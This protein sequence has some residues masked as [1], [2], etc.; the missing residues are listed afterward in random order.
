MAHTAVKA[1]GWQNTKRHPPVLAQQ[2]LLRHH[3]ELA[4]SHGHRGR[5]PT[6]VSTWS[7]PTI[8]PTHNHMAP[9]RLQAVPRI[10]F[11]QDQDHR[12][13]QPLLQ[14]LP[15]PHRV[16]NQ[17]SSRCKA[18]RLLPAPQ[19]QYSYP[20]KL[21]RPW[22]HMLA[23]STNL[24]IRGDNPRTRARPTYLLTHTIYNNYKHTWA[25][26][27]AFFTRWYYHDTNTHTSSH[28]LTKDRRFPLNPRT[29]QDCCIKKH[30]SAYTFHLIF[31]SSR[32]FKKSF[33]QFIKEALEHLE[34]RQAARVALSGY[35]FHNLKGIRIWTG[36]GLDGFCLA[37][38][39]RGVNLDGWMNDTTSF[40]VI[41]EGPVS[42]WPFS[43]LVIWWSSRCYQR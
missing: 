39:Q 22:G 9:P 25:F 3:L 7:Q 2:L 16:L 19:N 34:G 18:P 4:Q 26:H 6:R 28:V 42:G 24:G 10:S 8:S 40:H 38:R 12:H 32:A 13:L 27:S 29:I 23:R 1:V 17:A 5:Q 41:K 35:T 21:E 37:G 43:G 30:I 20:T 11:S 14:S 36:Y 15:W 31:I 33:L